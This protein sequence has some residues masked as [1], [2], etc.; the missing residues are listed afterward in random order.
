M[1]L[2]R[3]TKYWQR[4][5]GEKKCVKCLKELN[6]LFL[7]VQIRPK[8]FSHGKNVRFIKLLKYV[9]TTNDNG[10]T[11]DIFLHVCNMFIPFTSC[12][13]LTPCNS[14]LPHYSPFC[15]QGV[16]VC[17]YDDSVTF[18]RVFY[19]SVSQGLLQNMG[20]LP[21]PTPLKK[22]ESLFSQQTLTTC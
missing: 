3:E 6:K 22:K 11:Y 19:R 1:I 9:L 14:L 7:S 8:R 10:F 13:S 2:A 18:L 16:C 17:V 20:T 12:P 5:L 4:R 15:F 21:M